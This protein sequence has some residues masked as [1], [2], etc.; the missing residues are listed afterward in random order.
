MIINSNRFACALFLYG[1]ILLLWWLFSSQV[2]TVKN[3]T[4]DKAPN[5][6]IK[7]ELENLKGKNIITLQTSKLITKWQKEYPAIKYFRI[8]K[9]LPSTLRVN[10]EERSK[11]LVWKSQDQYYLIDTSGIA[12]KKT[13]AKEAHFAI[14]DDENLPVELGRQIVSADFISSAQNILDNVPDII[15]DEKI[16]ELHVAESSF[17]VDVLT[18]ANIRLKFDITQSLPLQY[19]ALKYMYKEKRGDVKEYIDLRVVGKAYYK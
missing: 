13:S 9:G 14:V 6:N 2:F 18:G 7:A 5:E 4:Y 1:A 10:I 16:V 15:K 8:Y 3:I 19:E 17:S 12:Y 11:A